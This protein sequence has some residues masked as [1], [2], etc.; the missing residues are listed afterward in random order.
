MKQVLIFLCSTII[1][2]SQ[3]SAQTNGAVKTDSVASVSSPKLYFPVAELAEESKTENAITTLARQLIPVYEEKIKRIYLTTSANFNILT[4]NYSKALSLLD[5]A[6]KITSDKSRTIYS[7]SYALAKVKAANDHAAFDKIF[8]KEFET[9]FNNLSFNKKVRTAFVDSSTL[10]TFRK[11]YTNRV[12]NIKK[13]KTDSISTE[14]A[15][16]LCNSYFDYTL[17]NSTFALTQ[18]YITDLQ[19][20]K[21]YPAIK[22][23]ER[24]AVFPVTN[25]EELPDPK[26]KYKLLI[27]L[28]DFGPK[29]PD[30][31][32]KKNINQGLS[33]VGRFINLHVADGIP[34]EKLD[35]VIVVH[36]SALNA[37][38]NNEA[39]KKKYGV[40]NPNIP[41]LKEME[42]IGVKLLACGQAIL[43]FG[44]EKEQMLPNVKVVLTAQTVITSYQLKGYVLKNITL[45]E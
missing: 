24:S 45:S 41:V 37:F 20:K 25:V 3:L 39:Y 32:I 17:L 33:E 29:D 10:S 34:K 7:R 15:V 2:I 16:K 43:F 18:S 40:D 14:D 5:S 21:Y 1:V 42:S 35:V 28:V 19:Y 9:L 30:S 31:T 22:S 8:Q 27:E 44:L 12:D 13:N 38:L 6:D 23:S 4:N 36:A 11:T 26:M